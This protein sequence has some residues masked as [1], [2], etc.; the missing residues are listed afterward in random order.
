[1]DVR[2]GM[3]TPGYFSPYTAG[4]YGAVDGSGAPMRLPVK[5]TDSLTMFDLQRADRQT[6]RTRESL[7]KVLWKWQLLRTIANLVAVLSASLFLLLV[8]QPLLVFLFT[9][10]TCVM[11]GC[12]EW[13]EFASV[14][15]FASLVPGGIALVSL[16]IVVLAHCFALRVK[17]ELQSLLP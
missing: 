1:M 8:L 16:V 3:S 10:G 13:L 2:N 11:G 14:V 7:E 4:S 9:L 17:R 6:Y 15:L 12:E 5:S